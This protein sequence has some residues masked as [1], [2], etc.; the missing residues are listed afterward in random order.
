MATQTERVTNTTAIFTRDENSHCS[1][2]P[3]GNRIYIAPQARQ[4]GPD[5]EDDQ[6]AIDGGGDG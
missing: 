3:I 5:S 1:S 2:L 6:D 4:E